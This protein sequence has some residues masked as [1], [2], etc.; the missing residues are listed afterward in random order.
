MFLRIT[1]SRTNQVL[2]SLMHYDIDIQYRLISDPFCVSVCVQN[3]RIPV[4][5]LAL[6]LLGLVV[7]I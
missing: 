6:R 2:L 7:I 4:G 1:F 5:L 3:S